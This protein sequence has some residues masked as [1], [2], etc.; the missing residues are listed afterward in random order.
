MGQGKN[1][2]SNLIEHPKHDLRKMLVIM[3]ERETQTNM[4]K[5]E[6][7]GIGILAKSRACFLCGGQVQHIIVQAIR[8]NCHFRP[9]N[10]YIKNDGEKEQT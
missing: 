7:R 3:E 10:N 9:E 5:P 2:R 4:R 1:R 8:G 6:I